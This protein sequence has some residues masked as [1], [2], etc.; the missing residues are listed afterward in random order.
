MVVDVLPPARGKYSAADAADF[1]LPALGEHS[2]EGSGGAD[3]GG[4]RAHH[5][6]SRGP[7]SSEP[8]YFW[9]PLRGMCVLQSSISFYDY[10]CL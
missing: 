8:T 1:P 6:A 5:A 4:V 2:G 9:P 7:A 3:G 10:P